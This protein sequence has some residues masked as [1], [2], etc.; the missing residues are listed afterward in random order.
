MLYSFASKFRIRLLIIAVVISSLYL[1]GSSSYLGLKFVNQVEAQ[2]CSV[3]ND[4]L[5]SWWSF[6]GTEN[7]IAK[8]LIGENNGSLIGG[9]A[10]VDGK[11]NSGLYLDGINDE[12]KIPASD[13]LNITGDVT[14]ELWAKRSTFRDN[15]EII[16]AK[17]AGYFG[18]IDEPTV[19]IIGISSSNY[20]EGKDKI[21]SGFERADGSGA[22]I[23]G[24]KVINDTYFHHLL[25]ERENN[26]QRLYIDGNLEASGVF[27][28]IP[29]STS[30]IDLLIGALRNGSPNDSFQHFNGVVDEVKIYNRAL[31]ECE[32]QAAYNTGK[33]ID[34]AVPWFSQ[35][36]ENWNEILGKPVEYDFATNW[37]SQGTGIDRWG[38]ALT[39][40]A[41]VLMYH[42]V[43]RGVAYFPNG[44]VDSFPTNPATLN[45]WLINNHGYTNWGGVIWSAITKYAKDASES[46]PSGS[47]T[48]F[49]FSYPAYTGIGQV[50][51][52]IDDEVPEI[53]R[54]VRKSSG[55]TH[56]VVTGGFDGTD[57]ILINDP[58]QLAEE[59]PPHSLNELYPE[60]VYRR[61]RLG[62]FVPS[63]TDLSYLWMFGEPGLELEVD[64]TA[65]DL[66]GAFSFV[67]SL[68]DDIDPDLPGSP[69]EFVYGLP[70]PDDGMV[71][72]VKLNVLPGESGL[73]TID[74]RLFDEE[75][76]QHQLLINR[77]IGEGENEVL[78]LELS[79]S[80][81]EIIDL[82]VATF[83]Q[84]V[85]D[86]QAAGD[87][88][89]VKPES[90]VNGWLVQANLAESM[91]ERGQ[92]QV[93]KE[94]W[95]NLQREIRTHAPRALGEE[96]SELLVDEIGQLMG[97][98]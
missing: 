45:S 51:A 86:L 10:Y 56:F 48:T 66:A 11:I 91:Q 70:K 52:D 54:L 7:G 97:S 42:G 43:D 15:I 77:L 63:N 96:L 69:A 49:E 58:N 30:D 36:D 33:K 13:N 27:V 71:Y 80:L 94:I 92:N 39:S 14:V 61:S 88:G 68:E 38:C 1:I 2:G 18:T 6:D 75:G 46:A 55:N 72:V 29:G 31:S 57:D 84:L 87:L 3:S 53:L 76:N 17:G 64:G 50:T 81:D 67:E 59:E 4:G 89:L 5:V 65:D 9:P 85:G 32:V 60:S 78:T 73:K 28:G 74:V 83:D 21:L 37:S 62:R 98:I 8:D 23:F 16:I 35:L 79:D 24:S 20:I 19:Y 95:K 22:L 40:A 25:Y 41:M 34:L 90:L 44:D 47:G 26:T 82:S 93:A 12:V